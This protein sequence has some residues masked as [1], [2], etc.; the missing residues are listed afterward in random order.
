MATTIEANAFIEPHDPESTGIILFD[1]DAN[2]VGGNHLE[3]RAA[4]T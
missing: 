2:S 1:A 3:N 4:R